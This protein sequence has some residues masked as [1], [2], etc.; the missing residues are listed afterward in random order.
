[1]EIAL[2]QRF[3]TV[4]LDGPETPVNYQYALAEIL[5]TSQLVVVMELVSHQIIV[6]VIVDMLE[7]I[8]DTLYVMD[9]IVLTIRYVQATAIVR[10]QIRACVRRVGMGINA[11]F[12]YASA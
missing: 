8:V 2:N 5:Q 9:R 12:L 1:M 6:P 10:S 11:R 4:N 7:L 3:V